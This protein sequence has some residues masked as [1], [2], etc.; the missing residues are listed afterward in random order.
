LACAHE[1]RDA[2]LIEVLLQTGMCLSELA[3]L[4]VI[5][6]ELPAKI[7]HDPVHVGAVHV[8]GKGRK[9]RTVT[10]NWR[11]CKALK[12]YLLVRPTVDDPCIFVTKFRTGMSPRAIEYAVAKYLTQA[13]IARAH[14]HTLRHTFATHM[15]RKGTKLDVVRQALGHADLKTTSIYVDLARDVMDKELQANA[16]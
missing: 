3:R 10:L 12:L 13:G 16:L 11:A 7:S 14:V 1:P 4:R 6:V 2:A 8:L 5:D 9:D 15:V